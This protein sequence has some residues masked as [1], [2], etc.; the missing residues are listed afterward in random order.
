MIGTSANVRNSMNIMSAV[1][2][3][4]AWTGASRGAT[5]EDPENIEDIAA[6]D[7]ADGNI[8]LAPVRRHYG[9]RQFRQPH[10]EDF[11]RQP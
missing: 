10:F 2:I 4:D 11:F 7:V 9:S 6:D 3:P 8:R 1:L 5:P